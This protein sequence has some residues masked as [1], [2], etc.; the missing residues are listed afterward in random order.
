MDKTKIV[1]LH[2]STLDTEFCR[3]GATPIESMIMGQGST[4][5]AQES[6]GIDRT[7][8]LIITILRS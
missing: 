4:E 7:K 3:N 5:I 8:I 6:T 1:A 2:Y